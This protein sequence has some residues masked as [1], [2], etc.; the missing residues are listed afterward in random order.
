MKGF[1]YFLLLCIGLFSAGCSK[2]QKAPAAGQQLILYSE[3]DHDFTEALLAAYNQQQ[4]DKAEPVTY[5]AVYEL[6][7]KWSADLVLAE[8]RTLNGLIIDKRLQPLACA[9]GD[10]LPRKFKDQEHF[11]YGAFYD[12]AV[13]LVNQKFARQQG[14]EHILTWSDLE[15]LPAFNLTMENLSNSNSTKNFLGAMADKMGETTSLN[16]LWNLHTVVGQYAK[17]PFT[18]IRMTAVG[19][20]D[21]CLTRRSYVFKYLDNKFPAYVVQPQEGTPVN[22]YGVGVFKECGDP[23]AAIDFIE[24]L[25]AAE[26][27]QQVSQQ[28]ASGYQFLFP[29][30]ISG[31]AVKEDKLWLNE[32]YLTAAPQARLTD[33]WLARVRFSK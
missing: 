31:E 4:A 29:Q 11:W 19:D 5:R 10:R 7:D 28:V 33:K 8:R 1:I 12:P 30:G 15:N 2:E 20:A 17:F 23:L 26:E 21:I 9:L 27:S 18:P 14:Q 32:T 25:L 13:F 16:Y 22:L 3:L 6:Q 24:W